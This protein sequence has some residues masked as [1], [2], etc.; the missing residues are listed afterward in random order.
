MTTK[1]IKD[2][3]ASIRQRLLNKS[4]VEKRS[5][6]E[7]V[8]RYA[9]ERF[10]Y[11]LGLSEHRERL[12]LKGALM[13]AAW[14]NSIYRPTLDIDMLGLISND[15]ATLERCI[16]DICSVKTEDDGIIFD[17]STVKSSAI[18]KDTDYLGCRVRFTG[19][20]ENMRIAM[21]VDIGFGDVV[22]PKPDRITIPSFIDMPLARVLGYTRE[23][24]IAEKYH[25]MVQMAELN[26]RMKDFYDIWVLSKMFD[27]SGR[28]L[29]EA[30]KT[31]F[32]RRKTPI[33]DEIVAFTDSFARDKQGQW[34]AFRKKTG[35]IEAPESFHEIVAQIEKFLQPVILFITGKRD[36]PG[37]WKAPSAWQF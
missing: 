10:L 19:K 37:E 12:I 29:A 4:K 27:F 17:P 34:L 22:F 26:S 20:M 2:A 25:V 5:F 18:T 16:R 8:R 21:Q 3:A 30:I 13:F 36:E 32:K 11:R 28:R 35:D 1:N 7:I 14:E 31:T 33:T 15:T 9:M 6:E 23:S 24:V